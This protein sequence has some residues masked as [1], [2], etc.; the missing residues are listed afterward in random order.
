[1]VRNNIP[2]RANGAVFIILAFMFLSLP[3]QWI[4]AALLAAIV[5]ELAHAG[6]IHLCGGRINRLQIS[7]SGAAME[8]PPMGHPQELFCAL[9]GPMGGLL[10]LPL[11]RWLP[12]TAV[13]AAF[14]SLYN[15]LPVYPLDGGRAVRCICLML[16]SEET[17]GRICA[18]IS[19]MICIFLVII[20][21]CSV[22]VWKIGLLP[23]LAAGL[24]I[25]KIRTNA[26]KF[27]CKAT[28]GKVQ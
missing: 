5:H 15:L 28:R 8:I 11:A 19:F 3:L 4:G 7:I 25:F 17:A 18:V 13:C 20:A 14:H 16:F 26:V 2:L 23:A 10:L 1:M 22:F 27:P 12:R 6:A 9:A 21:I 24:T